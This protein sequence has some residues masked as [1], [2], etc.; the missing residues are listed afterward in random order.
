[1]VHG[2]PALS[3]LVDASRTSAASPSPTPRRNATSDPA[4]YAWGGGAP[5]SH[6]LRIGLTIRQHSSASSHRMERAGS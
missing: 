4:W 1:M 6:S 2:R 3:A 5:R